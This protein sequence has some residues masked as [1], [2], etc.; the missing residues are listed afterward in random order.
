MENKNKP[1]RPLI[2]ISPDGRYWPV[3]SLRACGVVLSQIHAH[4]TGKPKAYISHVAIQERLTTGETTWHHG[5]LTGW[6]MVECASGEEQARMMCEA[7]GVLPEHHNSRISDH[8]TIRI[9][10]HHN[11]NSG[12]TLEPLSNQS[13][14]KLKPEWNQSGNQVVNQN[15]DNHNERLFA[16]SPVGLP[17]TQAEQWEEQMSDL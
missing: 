2:L 5:P 16:D 14:T 3:Q 10:E 6:R 8:Q 1:A 7:L 13:E 4:I 11:S 17:K 15:V 9:L 12:T